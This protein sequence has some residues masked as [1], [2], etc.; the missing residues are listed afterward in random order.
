MSTVVLRWALSRQRRSLLTWAVVLAVVCTVYAGFYPLMGDTLD[1]ESL[2]ASLPEEFNVALGYDR[3]GTASGYLESTVYG[4]LGVALMLVFGLGLAARTLAGEEESGES[5]LETSAPVS[6]RSVLLQR[7]LALVIQITVLGAVVAATVTT[8]VVAGDIDVSIANVLVV[9]ATLALFVIAMASIAFA[10]G[11]ATGRRALALGAGAGVAV[12]SFVA[13]AVLPLLDVPD[14]AL[15]ISPFSWYL[16]AEPLT[17]G[18]DVPGLVG[19]ASIVAIA[20]A[21]AVV[22]YDRRDLGV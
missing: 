19:L 12:A 20:L 17:A 11:A 22:T 16:G 8:I 21:V 18:A 1:L 7:H 14:W 4:L 6:R 13:E 5:E 3:I 15:R 2:I 10:V 9:S